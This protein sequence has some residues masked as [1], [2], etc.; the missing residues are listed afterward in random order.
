[1]RLLDSRVRACVCEGLKRSRKRRPYFSI[2][3][4]KLAALRKG[5][6]GLARRTQFLLAIDYL[7]SNQLLEDIKTE[8]ARSLHRTYQIRRGILD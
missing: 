3:I 8:F 2:K 6:R 1:M 7:P 5:V 4:T